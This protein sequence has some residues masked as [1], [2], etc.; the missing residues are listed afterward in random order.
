MNVDMF[1]VPI[2]DGDI[3]FYCTESRYD[4]QRLGKVFHQAQDQLGMMSDDYFYWKHP[5]FRTHNG[6][7]ALDGF[8]P[9]R[10]WYSS[11]NCIVVTQSVPAEIIAKLDQAYLDWR[12]KNGKKEF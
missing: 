7:N 9:A 3:V 6:T 11:K 5:T 1:G 8:R 10:R 12:K 2:Q 4:N